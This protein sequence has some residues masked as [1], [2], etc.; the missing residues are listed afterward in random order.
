MATKIIYYF[1][2]IFIM[3]ER[4]R[5]MVKRIFWIFVGVLVVYLWK[6]IL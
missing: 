1:K 3:E 6:K 2:S 4:I 5:K